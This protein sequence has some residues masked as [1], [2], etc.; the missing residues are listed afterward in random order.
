[1]MQNN[2]HNLPLQLVCL[3]GRMVLFVGGKMSERF[4][5]FK[6]YGCEALLLY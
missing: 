1:M 3:R 2:M 5:A 4:R 6:I